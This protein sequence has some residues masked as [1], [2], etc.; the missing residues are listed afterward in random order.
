MYFTLNFNL[1]FLP[2][3][4]RTICLYCQFL[5]RSM[6][7]P[8]VRNYLSGV[9]LLHLMLGF[10]FP[11]LSAHEL[12]VTL[13]GIE[14]LAQHR[15][16]RAPPITPS[17]LSTLVSCGVDFDPSD[18]TFSCAFLFAF[19]LFARISNLVPELGATEHKRICR[20]DVAPT[21][22]GLCVQFTWSKTIQFG[23]RVLELPLVRVPYSPL[24]PVRMFYLMCELVPAPNSAPLFVLPSRSGRFKP[25]L[26]SHFVS[27]LRTRLQSAGVPQAHLFRG[28]SFRRG[29]TSWAFSSGIPGELIQVFGDWRS[30]AYKCYLDISMPLKLR[31]SEG[32]VA[33]LEN[34]ET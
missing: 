19:F 24:C 32:M 22:Y 3:S 23:H 34:P 4:L 17:L 10:E 9:K 26:K 14:R 2:A 5:S 29:G 7:P 18:V 21:H 31:V 13:R 28:H 16:H 8:S 12:K 27:V 20:G 33:R 30:D 11:D 1:V 15:P 6:T 25:V